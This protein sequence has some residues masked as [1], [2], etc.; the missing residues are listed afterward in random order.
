MSRDSRTGSLRYKRPDT[1]AH[2]YLSGHDEQLALRVGETLNEAFGPS[3]PRGMRH[4]YREH[5]IGWDWAS[6]PHD[7]VSVIA[8]RLAD[9]LPMQKRVPAQEQLR[10][11]WA[12]TPPSSAS[13]RKGL[14]LLAGKNL[15]A[16]C[17]QAWI[18]SLYLAT[19]KNAK[20]RGINFDLTETEVL[21]LVVGSKGR[22]SVTGIALSN[23]R[24]ELAPGRRMRRPWAP[25]IDRVDSTQ[26]YAYGNCRIVCCAANYAMSQWGED[27]LVEMAKAIA[28]R[29][30]K[31]MGST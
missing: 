13:M 19:R 4:L 8:V 7:V 14:G 3:P 26:G 25:S 27:V 9:V 18:R 24:G 21:E 29:R 11:S 28:R 16:A 23:D 2:V 17:H 5:F 31:R 10:H 12:Y 30:I 20:A 22:C 1:G 6:A 15:R